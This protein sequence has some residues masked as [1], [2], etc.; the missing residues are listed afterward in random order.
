MT[1]QKL[2]LADRCD[3]CVATARVSL[4]FHTGGMLQFCKH[5][6]ERYGRSIPAAA[7]AELNDQRGELLAEVQG[8]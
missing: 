2:T 8:R 7:V 4:A 1:L 3:R 5:H 6:Y